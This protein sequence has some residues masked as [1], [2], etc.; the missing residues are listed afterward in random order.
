MFAG[1]PCSR[2]MSATQH[3]LLQHTGH[4]VVV[5]C[6]RE[7]VQGQ[8]SYPTQSWEEMQ[9]SHLSNPGVNH[10]VSPQGCIGFPVHGMDIED[11]GK[12]LKS[13]H[14]MLDF[15]ETNFKHLVIA[16]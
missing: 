14:E 9:A 2:V 7:A 5:L 1:L 16:F 8:T 12:M 13:L 15:Q 4:A 11:K 10:L 3:L 6:Q